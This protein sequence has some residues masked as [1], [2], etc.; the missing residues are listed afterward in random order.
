MRNAD[1][2]AKGKFAM[3][4]IV[5][6]QQNRPKNCASAC[7]AMVLN[8][9]IDEITEYFQEAYDSGDIL[10]H[11][12]LQKRGIETVPM[13]LADKPI[14]GFVYFLAVPSLN[15][16]GESH[17]VIM[18]FRSEEAGAVLIDPNKGREGKEWYVNLAEGSELSPGEFQ[19]ITCNYDYRLTIPAAEN[20]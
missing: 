4:E 17:Q 1:Q 16:K 8:L 6:Q 20:D 19:V 12:Y 11:D 3:S 15:I 18:D 9:P 2:I 7:V 14:P 10:I 13:S 5:F